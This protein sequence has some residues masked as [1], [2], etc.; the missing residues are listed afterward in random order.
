M[1]YKVWQLSYRFRFEELT[2]Y[3]PT[4]ELPREGLFVEIDPAS[5]S[6]RLFS[7]TGSLYT[8]LSYRLR[9]GYYPEKDVRYKSK[10]LVGYIKVNNVNSVDPVC[11]GTRL[12][13][14]QW[15]PEGRMLNMEPDYYG[16]HDWMRDVMTELR[17]R[18]LIMEEAETT[19]EEKAIPEETTTPEEKATPEANNHPENSFC[20]AA[21]KMMIGCKGRV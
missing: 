21:L 6:G 1:S 20:R 7:V 4:V 14:K 15:D 9:D 3:T 17:E 18:K 12:V 11:R 5:S 8:G 10:S 2:Y 19:P 16:R 13:E